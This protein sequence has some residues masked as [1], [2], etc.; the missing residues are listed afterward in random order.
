M[1]RSN[2]KEKGVILITVFWVLFFLAVTAFTLGM[3]ARMHI[4]IRSLRN[5]QMQMDQ[6]ARQGVDEMIALL[7]AD[8]DKVDSFQDQW[9]KDFS[10]QK[11]YGLLSCE[12]VDEDRFLNIN[13]V[14]EPVLENLPSLV[15]GLSQDII[16]KIEKQRPFNVLRELMDIGGVNKEDYYASPIGMEDEFTVFSDGKININTAPEQVLMMVPDMTKAA[17][18]T[19]IEKRRDTPF[20]DADTLSDELSRLGLSAG[21]VSSLIKIAKVNSSCFLI[22]ARAVSENKRISRTL[23]VVAKRKSRKFKVIYDREN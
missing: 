13:T 15:G 2:K 16:K 4:R 7:A 23:Y 5:T 18:D 22:T 3:R 6:L 10:L 12:V 11:D 8:D 1:I 9:T 21:Q 19:I 14:P 20:A 17:A